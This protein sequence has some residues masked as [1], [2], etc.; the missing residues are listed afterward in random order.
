MF[1]LLDNGAHSIKLGHDHEPRYP[2][3]V[4]LV[5]QESV[6]NH[7]LQSHPSSV[8]QNAIIRSKGDKQTYY[9]HEIPLCRDRSS[10]H[11]RLPCEKVKHALKTSSS[12]HLLIPIKGYVVDWDAQKA[13]WDGMF[14]RFLKVIP[15]WTWSQDITI[16]R[17]GSGGHF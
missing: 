10:L 3:F 14:L 7:T 13:I 9:G 17:A 5:L 16:T 1:F 12:L 11:Y 6:K 4:F 8:F 2:P 15:L